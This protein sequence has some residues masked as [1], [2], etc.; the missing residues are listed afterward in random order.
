MERAWQRVAV[1]AVVGA[2]LAG[3]VAWYGLAFRGAGP[4]APAAK[5]FSDA[6]VPAQDVPP[7]GE[8]IG[9]AMLVPADALAA[10]FEVEVPPPITWTLADGLPPGLPLADTPVEVFPGQVETTARLGA[11]G[12][13]GGVAI[14]GDTAYLATSDTIRAVELS[15]DRVSVVAGALGET[16]CAVGTDPGLTRFQGPPGDV[17]AAG[18]TLYV[19]GGCGIVALDLTSGA[20]TQVASFSGPMTLGPDGHLYVGAS[21]DGAPVIARVDPASEAVERYLTLPTGAAV[22]GLAADAQYVWATVDEGPSAPTVL[23]RISFSDG[24]VTRGAMEGV[25]V[26][27]AG[28]LVSA[29]PY[30][31]APSVGNLG[32]LRFTKRTGGWGLAVGGAQGDQ[33]GVWNW[34]SFGSVRGLASDGAAIWIADSVNGSLRRVD[35]SPSA[36]LSFG[37]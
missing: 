37:P 1:F 10:A 2:I 19:G 25:D 20:S 13:L 30:L 8:A 27:G 34:A 28:Q 14:V 33:D 3:F 26:A 24:S 21:E 32:L 6:F 9:T 4:S 18:D 29:G 35:F 31:Y 22:L 7:A 23:Y 11:A 12:D 5:G 16:G 15:S 17:V 36:G